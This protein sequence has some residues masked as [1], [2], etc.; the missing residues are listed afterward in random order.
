MASYD[1]G[2]DEAVKWVREHLKRGDSCL[3]VGACD[4]KWQGMLGDWLTM[5]AVEI[6]GPNISRHN[7]KEKYR[8]VYRV[9]IADYTYDWY[10]LIIFGDV[11]EHMPVERAQQVLKYAENRCRYM[12]VSV[13]FLY[14]QDGLYGN[15]WEKHIQDDLTPEIFQKR[16]PGFQMLYQPD[17]NYSYYVK[18]NTADSETTAQKRPFFSVIIPS[19]NGAGYIRTMLDSIRDQTFKD[20][21]LIV[22]CDACTDNTEEIARE[23]GA[24]ILTVNY[25]RDGLTRNAGIEAARGEWVLFAD[26]DDRWLHEHVFRMLHDVVGKCGEDV[27]NYSFIWK[28]RGYIKQ[29]PEHMDCMA[30]CRCYR[31]RF[32]KRLRF[33]RKAYASDMDFFME[34]GNL[35]PRMVWWNTPMYYY[36][37]LRPGS[38]TERKLANR[39]YE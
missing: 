26:D 3:D 5:D 10:D 34:L 13:P 11:I 31:T 8:A 32:L 27:L 37:W 1:I 17:K 14:K 30:W 20:Y 35:H 6:F 24:R 23:Y 4:G 19:H 28:G 25:K 7:L 29:T 12:I 39:K 33:N 22:V 15:K 18:E 16:Y 38:L 21:E 36:N 2:K 9:D